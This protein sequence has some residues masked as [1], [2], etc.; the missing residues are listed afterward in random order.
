MKALDS[1]PSQ[2]VYVTF[3]APDYLIIRKNQTIF[4]IC[5]SCAKGFT[6]PG[7][8]RQRRS[9]KTYPRRFCS[10]VC[11]LKANR[12]KIINPKEEISQ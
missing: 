9:G 2:V 6:S 12:R 3:K 7:R 10:R 8:H 1:A 5:Q 4:L 11:Y